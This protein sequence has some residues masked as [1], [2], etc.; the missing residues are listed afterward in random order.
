MELPE[1]MT[2]ITIPTPGGPE[3]LVP[4]ERPVPRPG[5][6]ELLIAVAAAGVNRPDV[7]QRRG[8][9][10]PPPGASDI[11]GLEIAG[12]VVAAGEGASHFV[13]QPMCALVAGGGYAQYAI[14]PAATAFPVPAGLSL[15]EAA[16]MPETLFTVWANL[17]ERGAA[18]EG[19]WVLVHG[20]TSGIGTMAIALGRLFGLTMIVTCGSDEKCAR[21]IQIGAN[22]AINYAT[23]DFVAEVARITGGAGCAA[24]LDMV[25][26]DYVPRNLQCLADDG[27]HVSIAVLGGAKTEIFIPLLMMKR[28]TLTGSTLRA[29]NLS[30]KALV[31]EEI[32]RTV[33]PHVEAGRLRPV[34]DRVFP[35]NDAAGAHALMDSGA[36]VGK[37]VLEVADGSNN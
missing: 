22:H 16:A 6:G 7:L 33:W 28:L 9:Y 4:T 34:I 30:F 12:T 36:H 1:T 24:V 37:I 20:G 10:P 29:R 3:A 25:G 14:A 23:Q 8:F 21:A 26:G 11:P 5:P 2:A 18:A 13:G 17:F 19:D 31:A 15:A 27:R 32:A 35:L